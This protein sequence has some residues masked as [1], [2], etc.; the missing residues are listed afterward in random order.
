M[1]FRLYLGTFDVFTGTWTLKAKE[2]EMPELDDRPVQNMR[3][4]PSDSVQLVYGSL[5]TYDLEAVMADIINHTSTD[6]ISRIN[7]DGLVL[8]IDF[9]P[10]L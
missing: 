1:D 4:V 9:K 3:A 5:H 2:I 6:E 10:A 8:Q 7:Y